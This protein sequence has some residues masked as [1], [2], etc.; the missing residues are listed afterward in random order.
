MSQSGFTWAFFQTCSITTRSRNSEMFVFDCFFFFYSLMSRQAS[1][2]LFVF[3]SKP[4]GPGS[5]VCHVCALNRLLTKSIMVCQVSCRFTRTVIVQTSSCAE[6]SVTWWIREQSAKKKLASWQRRTGMF[7]STE[8]L[9]ELFVKKAVA[10]FVCQSLHENVSL[11]PS[12]L[13]SKYLCS[14][15]RYPAGHTFTMTG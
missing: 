13:K 3:G 11:I 15:A 5:S 7:G 4:S 9:P 2:F 6:T 1:F 10:A 8:P 14:Y 12:S